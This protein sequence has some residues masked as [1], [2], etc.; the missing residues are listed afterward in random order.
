MLTS[1]GFFRSKFKLTLILLFIF[2]IPSNTS[3]ASHGSTST[4]E[5]PFSKCSSPLPIY[6]VQYLLPDGRA[7]HQRIPRK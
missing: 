3:V 6:S 1:V 4:A 5:K 7:E 2:R